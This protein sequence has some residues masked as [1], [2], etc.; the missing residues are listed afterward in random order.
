MLVEIFAYP[1]VTVVHFMDRKS[2]SE[3]VYCIMCVMIC[4]MFFLLRIP[5]YSGEVVEKH[6]MEKTG[7][8]K[9]FCFSSKRRK[10]E[11]VKQ[12]WEI[13][14]N[15]GWNQKKVVDGESRLIPSKIKETVHSLRNPNHVNKISY[16]L[17][18]IWC[19]LYHTR[20][21]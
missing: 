5:R 12:F 1:K 3:T 17:P 10:N 19:Y 6:K 20:E 18:E 4:K 14:H 8:C 2:I 15:F 7:K 11:I 9:A 13:D 21:F 16:K